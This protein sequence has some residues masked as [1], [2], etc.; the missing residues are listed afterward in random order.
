MYQQLG[1]IKLKSGEEVEAGV[2]RGPD[3]DWAQR[4]VELLWHK[5]D[6]WNWQ[7]A[8]LLER[9]SGLDAFFYVLH[10]DGK[11][12]A[13]IMTVERAG[14][15]IF[16]HVWTQ[17][18]DRQ[19]GASSSLMRIQMQDFVARG[20]QALFL[21]TGYKSVAYQ[22]Y[23]SFGFVGI[24]AESGTMAYYTKTPAA[25]EA[26]YFAQ[27]PLEIQPLAWP[28]WSASVPLF[29]GDYP[30]SVRSAGLQLF[31][32]HSTESALLPVLV[33]AA[34]HQQANEPPT[35]LTLCNQATT[36][37]V[38]L[39][40]WSWHP[41][42]PDTCLVDCYCHPNYWQH[43]PGLLDALQLPPADRSL[44]YVDADHTAKLNLFAKA[45]FKAVTTLPKWIASDTAKKKWSD[46]VVMQR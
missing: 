32:R 36:A 43:A 25:F 31:G 29:V 3:L 10:R 1:S 14:V 13:N 21:N 37:V 39:A 5:G 45:G 24:E 20:G 11:P 19:Q 44:V 27:G 6:P 35:V 46:V 26:A 16:G 41:L 9:D 4:L 15:G 30:G 2:V 12:F 23:A 18:T 34:E 28:H 40:A 33:E 17:P 22:M 42:W 38:G 7:N 8:Q